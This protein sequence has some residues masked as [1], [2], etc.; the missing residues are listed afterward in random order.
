MTVCA[1]GTIFTGYD[2]SEYIVCEYYPPGN[3]VGDNNSYFIA[4]VGTLQG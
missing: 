2:A 4:N 3:V 1:D